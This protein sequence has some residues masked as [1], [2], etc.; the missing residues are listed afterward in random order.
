VPIVALLGACGSSKQSNAQTQ[1]LTQK[2][3]QTIAKCL[4][5]P[6][7]LR[8]HASRQKFIHCAVSPQH[9]RQ[10]GKCVEKTLLQGLPT[11]GRLESGASICLQRA[12]A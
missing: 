5:D 3:D 7:A 11:K 1:Q 2:A 8:S 10:L 6:L 12:G 9:E 4:P